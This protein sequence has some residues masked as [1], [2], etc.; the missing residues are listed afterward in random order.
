MCDLI[1]MEY[2]EKSGSYIHK[3][4]CKIMDDIL[5]LDNTSIKDKTIIGLLKKTKN[6]HLTIVNP[7]QYLYD[8]EDYDDEYLYGC[9]YPYEDGFWDS[10]ADEKNYNGKNKE[11]PKKI[12]REDDEFGFMHNEKTIKFYRD[13][14]NPTKANTLVFN[15]L[16]DFSDFLEEEG[17]YICDDD[18]NKA[19]IQDVIY[20]CINPYDK[21]ENNEPLLLMDNN[22]P[23]LQWACD[24]ISETDF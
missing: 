22:L 12:E 15:N 11:K 7:Y 24:A 10:Y 14:D 19:L 3:N 23:A 21:G 1:D 2:D 6:T 20:C 17:I 9:C 8:D 18:I 16:N 13:I 5:I 4:K